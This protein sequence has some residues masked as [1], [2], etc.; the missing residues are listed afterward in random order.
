MNALSAFLRDTPAIEDG[1]QARE[2]NEFAGRTER[3][4]KDLEATRRGQVDPLNEQVSVINASFRAIRDPL[5]R[6]LDELRTRLT[7]YVNKVEA[8]RQAEADRLAREAAEAE[9]AARK[10]EAAEAEAVANAAVGEVVDVGA[11]M[12]AADIAF[13]E[14]SEAQRAALI[15]QRDVTV[16]LRSVLGGKARTLR[17]SEVLHVTDAVAALAEL[18]VTEAITEAI[19]TSARAYR[20]LH[21]RLPGGVVAEK[22]RSM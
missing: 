11:A 3:T 22:V 15:A 19:L 9:A 18:G 2:A 20:K 14:Y 6:A 10:A 1:E 13:N 17:T 7:S 8:K 4:I 16:R 5:K 12:E 21:G